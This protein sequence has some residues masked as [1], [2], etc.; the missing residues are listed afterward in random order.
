MLIYIV[1]IYKSFIRLLFNGKYKISVSESD[2]ISE[3]E[4]IILKI[5]HENDSK[6]L[7]LDS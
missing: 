6:Q 2:N 1:I 5:N 3:S 4:D 7:K